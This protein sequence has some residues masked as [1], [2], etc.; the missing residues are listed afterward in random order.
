MGWAF[1]FLSSDRNTEVGKEVKD[2][3]ELTL[4]I[5]LRGTGNIEEII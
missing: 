5:F 3:L 1:D 2:D 4:C